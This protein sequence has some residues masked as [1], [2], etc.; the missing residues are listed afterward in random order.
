M[1]ARLKR[2][3]LDCPALTYGSRC[4][5]CERVRQ[6]LKDAKRGGH[7][8]W[9]RRAAAVAEHRDQ[10]GDVCPGWG[11][12]PHLVEPPNRLS[13]DHPTSIAAGGPGRPDAYAVLCVSC[14]S[15]KGAR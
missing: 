8:D 2:R 15:R 6:R 3:C 10:V 5:S 1:P 12:P 13:A 9:R 7:G 4:A 11:V 14:N